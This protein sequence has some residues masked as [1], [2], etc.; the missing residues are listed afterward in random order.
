MKSVVI[1]INF[2]HGNN[3][4]L[5]ITVIPSEYVEE[6]VDKRN[7]KEIRMESVWYL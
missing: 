6:I 5:G 1:K 4:Y 2:L 3:G 7:N